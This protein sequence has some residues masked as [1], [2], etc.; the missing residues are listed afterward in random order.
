MAQK[1]KNLQTC[2]MSKRFA[3]MRLPL[4]D[5]LFYFS[6]HF[7]DGHSIHLEQPSERRNPHSRNR[8]NNTSRVW[9]TMGHGVNRNFFVNVELC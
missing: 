1:V 8:L 9:Q 6:N 5:L 4:E 7:V 3:D 2:R